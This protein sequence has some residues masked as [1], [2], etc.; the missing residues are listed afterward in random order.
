V[1]A[2]VRRLEAVCGDTATEMTLSEHGL[3]KQLS[4][5]LSASP[6]EI[7]ERLA[8]LLKQNKALEKELKQQE[9]KSALGAVDEILGS[10]QDVDG[11]SLISYNAGESS[12]DSLR[13]LLDALRPKV[14]SGVVVL[15]G[16]GDGKAVFL[17]SVTDDLVGNGLHAGKLIGSVAKVCGGGGGGQPGKAQAGGKDASKIPDALAQVPDF[18]RAQAAG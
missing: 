1:S 5:T 2:G 9:A 4:G 12:M 10:A 3:I 11:V 8:T 18:V 7:P 6:E 16:A 13:G 15:A 14:A 17:V